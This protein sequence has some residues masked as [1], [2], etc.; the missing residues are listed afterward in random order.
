DSDQDKV[1]DYRDDCPFN[2]PDEISKGVTAK[3][4]PLDTDQDGIPDYAD[5]CPNNLPEE[6]EKGITLR[7]CSRDRDQD[8]VPDYS[9]SCPDNTAEELRF[10]IARNGCPQDSDKDL[11]PDYRDFCRLDSP[12]DLA[13][14]TDERG[15]PKD[16]DQDGIFDV[17]DQCPDTVA[18]MKVNKQGCPLVTIL[19]GNSFASAR[20]ALSAEGK[21]KL[22]EFTR[23]FSPSD[24]EK[25]SVAVHTDGQGSSSFN[26]RLSQQRADA[27]AHFLS[28]IGIPRSTIEARGYGESHPVADNATE[29]GRYKNR[30]I[31][32]TVRLKTEKNTL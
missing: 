8:G 24:V 13:Q 9:D 22:L 31:E 32:L 29:E 7:G 27:V 25:V 26:Q 5:A 17:Y 1:A 2:R 28:D 19:T 16:T 10:G 15:C 20:S 11:Y 23:T 14:G 4:C 3:G 6:I 30:R 18:G 12:S 21:L